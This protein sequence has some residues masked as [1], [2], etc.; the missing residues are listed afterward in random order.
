MSLLFLEDPRIE[1][2]CNHE[3][4]GKFYFASILEDEK[5][6]INPLD[7]SRLGAAYNL[8]ATGS[9]LS[10]LGN[11]TEGMT[12]A[13]KINFSKNITLTGNDEFQYPALYGWMFSNGK[14][15]NSII[16]N[17][18]D[19]NIEI[20]ISSLFNQAINYETISGSPRDLIT[21][22]GILKEEKGSIKET[23]ILPP[24]SVT[25]LSSNKD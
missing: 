18:S 24:Y 19:R 12:S 3:L 14:D 21:K 20:E 8:S 2:I 17:L 7:Q 16:T 23:I 13:Q 15:K 25:K 10:L 11:A 4:I 9:A 22:P 5:S 6:F 1:L